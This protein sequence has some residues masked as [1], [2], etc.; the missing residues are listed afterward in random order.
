[1]KRGG[2]LQR[3]TP[4]KSGSSLRSSTPPA[5]ESGKPA[6]PRRS[7]GLHVGEKKAKKLA[8]QRSGGLCEMCIPGICM[9]RATDFHHRRFR[10]Q[11]GKWEIVNGLH[12]CRPCHM[13]VTN[14][15]GHR[16]EYERKGWIVPSHG[17]PATTEVLMW[18]QGRQ[19]WFLLQED[20]SAVLAPWP[21][22]RPEH[23]DYIER[24][25]ARG[26]D[27]AA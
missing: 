20:G 25:P 16:A 5:E 23:P 6:K 18:H 9:M 1:M 12:G 15:N 7:T 13:A 17:D 14:T 21:E 22:G 24:P 2:P 19:D 3:K 27:G 10:S 26:L 8:K 4:L 11:G